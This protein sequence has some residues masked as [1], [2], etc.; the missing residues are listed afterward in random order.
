MAPLQKR[1]LYGLVFGIIWAIAIVV[2]FILKGGVGA[3]DED[4]GF[5]LIINGLCIN[6]QSMIS[7]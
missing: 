7:A 1:A 3:F 5:R 2:V 4:P 6:Y